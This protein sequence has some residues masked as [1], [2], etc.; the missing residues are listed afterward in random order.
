MFFA[1]DEGNFYCWIAG[2]GV[3][4]VWTNILIF[5]FTVLRLYSVSDTILEGF[6]HILS[7]L[8]TQI[9]DKI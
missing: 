2:G 8:G 1:P 4:D 7:I 9:K 6:G 3:Q 5:K